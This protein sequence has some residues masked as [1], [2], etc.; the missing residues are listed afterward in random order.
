MQGE[1]HEGV[2]WRIG[3]APYFRISRRNVAG[4]DQ[5]A[6]SGRQRLERPGEQIA[7]HPLHLI[8]VDPDRSQGRIQA[9]RAHLYAAGA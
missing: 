2:H 1:P 3:L 9:G 7:D 5:K 4:L 6:G 8:R